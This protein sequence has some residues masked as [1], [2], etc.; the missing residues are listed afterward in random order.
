MFTIGPVGSA[1]WVRA[2]SMIR[3]AGEKCTRGRLVRLTNR[4]AEPTGF[5]FLR[6]A[7]PQ[8]GSQG[9]LITTHPGRSRA[10]LLLKARMK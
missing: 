3:E 6:G 5:F 10:G 2:K 4:V 1:A 9:E 8:K 7:L